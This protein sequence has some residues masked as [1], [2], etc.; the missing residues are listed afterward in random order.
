MLRE[1]CKLP[2]LCW[3]SPGKAYKK[4]AVRIETCCT[5]QQSKCQ[6]PVFSQSIL[7]SLIVI[8]E[9]LHIG[10]INHVIPSSYPHHERV[11][12]LFIFM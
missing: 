5:S 6:N 8:P 9:Y 1:N 4:S 3:S 12:L 10:P 7:S 2:A 11:S